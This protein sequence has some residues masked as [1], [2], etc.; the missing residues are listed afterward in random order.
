M[1][2]CVSSCCNLDVGLGFPLFENHELIV[3]ASVQTSLYKVHKFES[4]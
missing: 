4:V 1:I 2:S 3:K